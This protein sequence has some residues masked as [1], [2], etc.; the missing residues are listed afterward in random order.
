[1][2]LNASFVVL[3]WSLISSS[4]ITR[5]LFMITDRYDSSILKVQ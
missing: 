5:I 3:S 4:D 2:G 1:V